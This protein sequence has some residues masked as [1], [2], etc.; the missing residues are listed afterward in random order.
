MA[1]SLAVLLIPVFVLVVLYKT[2]FSGDAPIPVKA[3]DTWATARHDA[4]FTVLEPQGLPG[5]W[6]VLSARY[7]GGTLRVG[8][9]TPSGTGIQLVESDQAVDQLLPAELGADARPGNLVPIGDRQ[10]RAYPVARNGDRALV[11]ADQGRTVVVIGPASDD[12]L[13]TF[14]ATLR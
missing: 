1:L 13:R 7:A 12:E 2:V 6:T 3:G 4:R 10:W 9:V 5:K 11:L 14:A 8:Y